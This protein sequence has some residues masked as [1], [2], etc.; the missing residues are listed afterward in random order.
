MTLN[1][2][3]AV[4]KGLGRVYKALVDSEVLGDLGARYRVRVRAQGG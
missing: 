1:Q 3:A 4:V 2:V